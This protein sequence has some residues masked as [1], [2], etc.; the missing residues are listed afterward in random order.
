MFTKAFR[1]ACIKAALYAV[2]FIVVFLAVTLR[3]PVSVL[4]ALMPLC[5]GNPLDVRTDA[6]FGIDLNLA[7]SI[8]MPLVVG[9]GVE[10]GIIVVQRWRQ[11]RDPKRFS[12]PASTGMG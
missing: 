12:L 3:S 10:Y 8:F 11:S 1:D 2:A 4:A 7:N 5:H 6:L 9:A